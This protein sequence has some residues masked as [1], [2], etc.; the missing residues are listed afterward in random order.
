MRHGKTSGELDKIINGLYYVLQVIFWNS[1]FEDLI[2]LIQQQKKLC[3]YNNNT[4]AFEIPSEFEILGFSN[5]LNTS[6]TYS[7]LDCHNPIRK[8]RQAFLSQSPNYR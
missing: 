4:L 5:F 1:I 6:L 3:S 8:I 2:P 7:L